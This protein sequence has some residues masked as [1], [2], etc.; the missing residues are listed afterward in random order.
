MACTNVYDIFRPTDEA[1]SK[2]EKFQVQAHRHLFVL[3]AVLIMLF[4]VFH[5]TTEPEAIDPVWVR[6]GI[7][8]LAIGTVVASYFFKG[9][10][11]HFEWWVFGV[12]SINVGWGL[13]I[14]TLNDFASDHEIGLL[15]THA[16]YPF[17]IGLGTDS[18][19][20]VVWFTLGSLLATVGAVLISPV[21]FLEET[22]LLGA[23]GTV[24]IVVVIVIQRLTWI[25]GE[26]EEQESRL[27]GLANSVPG[28][29]FQFYAR[30]EDR[31]HYFVSEHAEEVLGISAEPDKFLERVRERVPTDDRRRIL[32]SI[33]EAI[34]ERTTWRAE[35]P[36]EKPSGER[37]WLL[38]TSTPEVREE[39][40]VYNGFLLDITDRKKAEHALRQSKEEA[41]EASQVKT[42]MLANM[43]HEVRTPLTS[44]IGFSE[45]LQDN[46]E[47]EF[48]GFARRTHQ[49]SKRLLETLE[50]VLQLSKLEAGAATLERERVSLPAVVR[51]TLSLLKPKAEEKSITLDT[52]WPDHRLEGF[53]NEN[54]LRRISR[55]L[56]ENAIKFTPEG[57]RVMVRAGRDDSRALLEVED[58]GIGIGEENLPDIFQAFRQ[59]SEGIRS[60]Y[61]G[62]GL[63]LSIVDHLVDELGGTV[64]VETE[65]GE[66][67]CFIVELPGLHEKNVAA[68]EEEELLEVTG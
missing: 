61:E 6:L 7:S 54:A 45:I 9:V 63:G 1:L 44:I 4:G 55:N 39:E 11:R 36:F 14:V 16:I 38:G 41:E 3:G 12:L 57:G 15:L 17:V 66:G 67:T 64:E 33:E 19:R 24:S 58:T 60:E 8:A 37:I 25:Q 22:V 51:Q 26:L 46:L 31:G 32:R 52:L 21:P 2:R 65:K 49:S 53:W 18:I 59:E 35:F 68:A 5:N 13:T 10:R 62:S 30:E 43:S 42:A 47:G 29:V 34:S 56:V 50:S 40:I 27:R 23:M 28:V 48:R 20:R